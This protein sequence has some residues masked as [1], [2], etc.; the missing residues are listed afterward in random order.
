MKAAA[1]WEKMKGNRVRCKLCWRECEI[2]PGA[3]GFCGVRKNVNGRLYSLNYGRVIS[4]AVDPIEKK[5]F[6]HFAPGSRA[7]SFSSFGCNFACKFCCN[8]EISQEWKGILSLAEEK[9]PEEIVALAKGVEGV[10]YTYSEPTVWVEFL[11]DIAKLARKEKLYNTMVTNGYMQPSVAREIAK[12][13]DA[14]VID[15]KNSGNGKAYSE[16]SSVQHAERIF[17]NALEFYRKGLW[18]ELTNLIIPGY[19]DSDVEIR[20]FCRWVV[21]NLGSNVPVHFLRFF[22]S[23]KLLHVPPTP[24]EFLEKCLKIAKEEGINYAYLG[25]VPGSRYEN[26]YCHACGELLMERY[27]ILLRRINLIR[28]GEKARCPHCGEE[29]PVRFFER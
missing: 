7:F 13:V 2:T 10:S 5:P 12:Y 3:T 18:I 6:F 21:E 22:P 29:I 1:F 17:E 20:K 9:T 14:V 28:K 24:V 27:G 25:N 15:L 19:G 11:L 16:L 23:Y 26:T 8:Y 4:C